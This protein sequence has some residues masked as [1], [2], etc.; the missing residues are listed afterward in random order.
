MR[1]HMA[2]KCSLQ[3]LLYE[4][5]VARRGR[6]L[7]SGL[8]FLCPQALFYSL[9]GVIRELVAVRFQK[10]IGMLATSGAQEA[11]LPS[12]AAAPF[13]EEQVDAQADSLD[14]R[15]LSI[16]SLGLKAAGLPAIG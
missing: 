1:I 2:A 7:H 14:E 8:I 6:S 11:N 10:C 16:K 9:A 13:A 15:Q 12:I 4:R 3:Q 5:L